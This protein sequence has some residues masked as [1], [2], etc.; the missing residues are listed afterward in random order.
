MNNLLSAISGQFSKA[1]LLSTMLPVVVFVLL[2]WA[3]VIPWVPRSVVWLAWISGLDNE[4][5]LAALSLAVLLLTA[6]LYNLNV[7]VTRLYEGYPWRDSYLGKWQQSIQRARFE[8]AYN[9]WRG[10]P[11][12]LSQP[13]AKDE[14][15]YP[16]AM[17]YWNSLGR[18]LN[19]D[20]P[21]DA[22]GVLPTR[23]GN[24]IRSFEDY[25]KR[26]YGL[27]AIT[28][29]PRLV[30]QIDERYAA[31][32]DDAKSSLDFMLN[33]SLLCGL[34]AA[35]FAAV[36]LYYPVGLTETS[37]WS[38]LVPVLAALLAAAYLLYRLSVS[39]AYAWGT[40]VRGAFDL[41]RWKLLE[42][43][44]SWEKPGTRSGERELW[45]KISKLL[46]YSDLTSAP[47]PDYRP[48]EPPAPAA[49]AGPAGITLELCRGGRS[50]L[51]GRSVLQIAVRNADPTR[52][53][54]GVSVRERLPEGWLYEL[55]SAETDD[56]RVV[57]ARGTNPYEFDLGDLGA[58]ASVVLT[59]RAVRG[60]LPPQAA[61]KEP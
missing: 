22:G 42:G 2:T 48:E 28:L 33:S 7:P 16:K 20:F 26:Q 53:A 39:R 29:W 14:A 38:S 36:R 18:E 9:R 60:P 24:V 37:G 15:H 58:G 47:P 13:G 31:Q 1:L 55:G 51:L 45:D 11:R 61:G 59:Y 6:L 49:T 12:V 23:L 52:Q 3:L 19:T 10:L 27:E 25:P 50:T 4:W 5:R 8:Y 35:L 57:T 54:T 21:K 43:L 46:I 32:I 34:L 17:K 44:G 56:H 30:A 41:Y 40:M